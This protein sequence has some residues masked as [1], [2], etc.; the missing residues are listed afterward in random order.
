MSEQPPSTPTPDERSYA[1]RSIAAFQDVKALYQ[2][3]T[4][5]ADNLLARE[6]QRELLEVVESAYAFASMLLGTSRLAPELEAK[7]DITG[8]VGAHTL[9]KQILA[10][11]ERHHLAETKTGETTTAPDESEQPHD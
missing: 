8:F 1:E 2:Q 6:L 11:R 4:I 7:L 9:G 5:P 10:A 3:R